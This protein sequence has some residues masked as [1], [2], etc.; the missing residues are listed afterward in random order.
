MKKKIMFLTLL[1]MLL[2][3]NPNLIAQQKTLEEIESMLSWIEPETYY[4]G[5]EM[6]SIIKEI[7]IIA[8]EEI[9]V[10]AKETEEKVSA[11]WMEEIKKK[12][13]EKNIWMGVGIGSASA[14]LVLLLYLLLK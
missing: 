4:K 12:E 10:T 1:L 11:I 8:V 14:A 2:N 7:L 3:L 9:Q 5:S 6:K 13:V